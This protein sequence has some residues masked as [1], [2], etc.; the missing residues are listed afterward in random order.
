MTSIEQ[1]IA[2]LLPPEPLFTHEAWDDENVCCDRANAACTVKLP[3]GDR[4]CVSWSELAGRDNAY[5]F[6]RHLFCRAVDDG[7]PQQ[8]LADERQQF[9]QLCRA[10]R[11]QFSPGDH[12][13]VKTRSDGYKIIGRSD[14]PESD[15]PSCWLQDHLPPCCDPLMRTALVIP[16][17]GWAMEVTLD[18]L[19]YQGYC[20]VEAAAEVRARGGQRPASAEWFRPSCS[21]AAIA[22]VALAHCASEA[23]PM[24]STAEPMF[25]NDL[26]SCR[27]CGDFA[28]WPQDDA[29]QVVASRSSSSAGLSSL[30]S[31]GHPY[32]CNMP[33]KYVRRSKGCRLQQQCPCCHLCHWTRKNNGI[34]G[35]DRFVV[36]CETQMWNQRPT[37][38]TAAPLTLL[39]SQDTSQTVPTTA[40]D[41]PPFEGFSGF[42]LSPSFFA[43]L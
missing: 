14:S 41:Y 20:A 3:S 5:R 11:K 4:Y 26:E 1:R 35:Y 39:A 24:G 2:Q 7:I 23:L 6:A 19:T 31:A 33:C 13:Y 9:Y 8:E 34:R 15:H 10:L 18:E 22:Q 12:L 25:V 38:A 43:L 27:P 37:D 32:F 28:H 40:T 29:Q 42:S 16:D 30:G 17:A 36:D 21:V